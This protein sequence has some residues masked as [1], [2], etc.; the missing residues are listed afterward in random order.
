M[1]IRNCQMLAI[2]LSLYLEAVCQLAEEY[3]NSCGLED[4]LKTKSLDFFRE[5]IPKG[6]DIAS[7]S[8]IRHDYNEEKGIALLKKSTRV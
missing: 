4:K 6:Y 7:L 3:I 1:V 2:Y 5:D 8:L